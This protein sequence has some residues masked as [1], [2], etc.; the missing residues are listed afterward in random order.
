MIIT[1][2]DDA[3][4]FMIQNTLNC[5]NSIPALIK[6]IARTYSNH[7]EVEIQIHKS[8]LREVYSYIIN[9]TQLA[10]NANVDNLFVHARGMVREEHIV[11]LFT[12][13]EQPTNM[14]AQLRV[15]TMRREPFQ[16]E[17]ERLPKTYAN[18]LTLLRYR[19]RLTT[20]VDVRTQTIKDG[21]IVKFSF[22]KNLKK[23]L[24]EVSK[25]D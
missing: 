8:L 16:I 13:D 4:L 17:R 21:K 5:N 2:N 11:I 18:N 24:E 6:A 3:D 23:I 9:P 19:L 20:G 15:W 14:F 12:N 7:G 25:E 1:I 10:K 22:P